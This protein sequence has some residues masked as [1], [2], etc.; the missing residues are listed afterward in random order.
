MSRVVTSF[1]QSAE[2]LWQKMESADFLDF[3]VVPATEA[4]IDVIEKRKRDEGFDDDNWKLEMR[5]EQFMNGCKISR[6]FY[7]E[8]LAA[9]RVN[10]YNAVYLEI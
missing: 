4:S 10:I 6:A 5:L 3:G 7:K 1:Y 8:R 9:S 2:Q